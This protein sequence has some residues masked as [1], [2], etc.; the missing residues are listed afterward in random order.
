MKKKELFKL[1]SGNARAYDS[2]HF[3]EGSGYI[4][5][6]DVQCNGTEPAVLDCNHRPID[7]ENCNHSEDAGVLCQ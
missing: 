7:S 5:L 3:G 1:S 6:D 4:H 2:A